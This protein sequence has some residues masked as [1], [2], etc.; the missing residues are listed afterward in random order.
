[1]A[2]LKRKELF[3]KKIME[4]R[5]KSVLSGLLFSRKRQKYQTGSEIGLV[6]KKL[7]PSPIKGHEERGDWHINKIPLFKN[8]HFRPGNQPW[9]KSIP[10]R[11]IAKKEEKF[12]E[13]FL[14]NRILFSIQMKTKFPS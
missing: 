6:E 13:R 9:Q 7:E 8:F 11:R 5:E 3:G 4:D 12:E 1:M 2:T 14:K 10:I